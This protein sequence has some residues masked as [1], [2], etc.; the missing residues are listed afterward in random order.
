MTITCQDLL[1]NGEPKESTK[2]VKGEILKKK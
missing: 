1:A 2:T